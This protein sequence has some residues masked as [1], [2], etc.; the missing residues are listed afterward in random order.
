MRDGIWV[1]AGLLT[2]VILMTVCSSGILT[3]AEETSIRSLWESLAGEDYQQALQLSIEEGQKNPVY[4]LLAYYLALVSFNSTHQI[5]QINGEISAAEINSHAVAAFINDMDQYLAKGSPSY[6]L[7][8]AII[9]FIEYQN[10]T[11]ATKLVAEALREKETALGYYLDFAFREDLESLQKA[12]RLAERPGFM[13]EQLLFHRYNQELDKAEEVN[14]EQFLSAIEELLSNDAYYFDIKDYHNFIQVGLGEKYLSAVGPSGPN[15]E[16]FFGPLCAVTQWDSFKK[17]A[18]RHQI[19]FTFAVAGPGGQNIWD[20]EQLLSFIDESTLA[21]Y[22]PLVKMINIY[23][24]FH[25]YQ[26]AEVYKGADELLAMA[27]T[28]PFYFVFIYDLAY[29][30]EMFYFAGYYPEQ[31][32]IDRAVQ[33]YDKAYALAPA[34]SAFWKECVLQGKGRSQFYAK[35]YQDSIDTLLL[36][37]S[38][39][40]DPLC[41]IFLSLDYYALGDQEN[42]AAWEAK[43]RA[44]FAGNKRVL[45][46]FEE[47][48]G[49]VKK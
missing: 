29:E 23:G 39:R 38:L 34:E 27:I 36:A 11:A 20:A 19:L 1:K 37:L 9:Q 25:D 12:V 3:A 6:K 33:L 7:V 46:Q 17:F 22:A 41:Y 14:K 18:P 45:R 35:R 24:N 47:L 2:L 43:V 28:D 48:L 26:Y 21:T 15:N 42:G 5:D 8:E 16:P 32:M 40:D 31:K 4:F 44:A 30:Y 10:P 13:Q 49:D